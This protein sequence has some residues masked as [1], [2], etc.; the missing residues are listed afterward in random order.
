MSFSCLITSHETR[1]VSHGLEENKTESLM[2]AQPWPGHQSLP[3]LLPRSGA[4]SR[5]TGWLL[6]QAW[7]E[8]LFSLYTSHVHG[9]KGPITLAAWPGL[10]LALG[11]HMPLPTC[12]MDVP[13]GPQS[14]QVPDE[15]CDLVLS[16]PPNQ[17][18][19]TA[20]SSP[21]KDCA[22][23]LSPMSSMCLSHH[24]CSDT[25]SE[26]VRTHHTELTSR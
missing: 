7:P 9:F 18:T 10:A 5:E 23:V 19:H 20:R 25:T 24:K 21:R 1:L 17:P 6:V 11:S 15:T 4:L 8:A 2:I 13:K 14:Q 26:G 16:Q 12:Y 3:L 22:D